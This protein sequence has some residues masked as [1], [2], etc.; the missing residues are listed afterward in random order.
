MSSEAER[1]RLLR[2]VDWRF[3]A[4]RPRARRAL[5][6]AGGALAQGVSSI[7]D[8]VVERSGPGECDLAVL[9]DPG[10]AALR[11]AREALEPGGSCYVEW[12]RPVPGGARRRLEAAGFHEVACH[13]PWPPPGRRTP[14]FWV[15]IDEPAAV[16]WFLA[17]RPVPRRAV[18]R[19]TAAGL[20]RAWRLL[21]RLQLLVPVCAIAR[22][23]G[24]ANGEARSL[25]AELTAKREAWGLGAD[26]GS[27]SC[28]LLT[29]GRR[30]INKVVALVFIPPSS[31][32][33]IVLKL[34][35]VPE[36]EAPL[37]R[38]ASALAAVR[39]RGAPP[40]VPRLLRR[41][42]LAASPVVAETVVD[43]RPLLEVLRG[44]THRALAL[45]V[46]DFL[47]ALAVPAP[48]SPSAAWQDRLVEPALNALEGELE[49]SQAQ[50]VRAILRDLGSLP[51]A[52]EQRDCS[53]WNVLVRPG[54]SL[55]MLDWESAEPDG[56]PVLDL[57]YY[58]SYASFFVDGTMDSGREAES[59]AAMLD[60]RSFTGRVYAECVSRYTERVGLPPTSVA[61]LRLLCWLVH[62]GAAARRAEAARSTARR[63]PERD[64]LLLALARAE[65]ANHGPVVVSFQG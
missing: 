26:A 31:E 32:P 29:G 59:Y 9:R 46:T 35:R 13:W 2:R 47:T 20:R 25:P 40:G 65:L 6:W 56:V 17:S 8:E 63:P 61:P 53:P 49:P 5:C 51:S 57:V 19:A 42:L 58:L 33:Q 55:A 15:P 30:A 45:Q 1:N 37:R 62:A 7:A 24:G 43:G 64:R 23:P 38:E 27:V 4:G 34:P 39:A 41:G 44:D 18:A 10:P 14:L 3:L 60:P 52:C 28:L 48:P 36:A 50:R 12:W 16:G 22:K 54:G 21:W 11:R